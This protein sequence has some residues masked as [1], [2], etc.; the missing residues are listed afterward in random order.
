MRN[1]ARYSDA[2]CR[3]AI[4]IVDGPARRQSDCD[5]LRIPR[6]TTTRN[7][8]VE[9]GP[10]G[11]LLDFAGSR[12]L[13]RQLL[14]LNCRSEAIAARA[15][16]ARVGLRRGAANSRTN[17]PGRLLSVCFM[18]LDAC[19]RLHGRSRN[20]Y[21]TI[22]ILICRMCRS[23]GGELQFGSVGS[24]WLP[25]CFSEISK[26]GGS[27]MGEIGTLLC[28][29]AQVD[30]LAKAALEQ[31]TRSI[32]HFAD[33]S[34]TFF[35]AQDSD[36]ALSFGPFCA[37]ALLENACAA[38]VGRLDAFRMLYLAEFQAQPQYE[39]G[40]RAKSAFSWSG[41]VIPDEKPSQEMWS[42]DHDVPKISR[43][44]FS[45]YVAHVF[46]KPAVERMVDFINDQKVD[47]DI[48]DLL[49]LDSETYVDAA[50]G[51][52]LQLYSTLSK[53]VHWE[54]FTS[55]LLFDEATVKNMIRDTCVLVSQLGLIS[56]FI[57]TAHASLS[58]IQ[59]LEL[60]CTFRKDLS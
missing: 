33:K 16:Q 47:V 10:K 29:V 25:L 41:D 32:N 4:S 40:K 22:E 28:G 5:V 46:W 9:L 53:G 12:R 30:G 37:R 55:A 60:Y 51:K 7:V 49:S 48:S 56:H 26:C 58:H 50:K 13:L 18:S 38:L 23:R 59:A 20:G 31:L 27:R 8:R 36:D 3:H 42:I 19:P 17:S 14:P 15:A 6:T 2:M 43:A 35:N 34:V 44:L 45:R 1:H 54:F 52:S 39:P 57:P 24:D 11:G 21:G